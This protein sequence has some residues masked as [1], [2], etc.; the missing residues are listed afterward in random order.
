MYPVKIILRN[1][2][3]LN[4][5]Y[6]LSKVTLI[7]GDNRTG[8]TTLLKA[9]EVGLTGTVYDNEARRN[10]TFD[11]LVAEGVNSYGVRTIFDNGFWI[12][13]N[14]QRIEDSKGDV[15]V[16]QQLD[17]QG[18]PQGAIGKIRQAEQAL[19]MV[20][21]PST[22]GLHISAIVEA[23]TTERRKILLGML[24]GATD[25][26]QPLDAL[27]SSKAGEVGSLLPDDLPRLAVLSKEQTGKVSADVLILDRL[28]R[29]NAA[30][31]ENLKTAKSN[32][33]TTTETIRTLGFDKAETVDTSEIPDLDKQV[34][35]LDT[36]IEQV[37]RSIG[38]AKTD[39]ERSDTLKLEIMEIEDR[40]K[41][42]GTILDRGMIEA[43]KQMKA[44]CKDQAIESIE[45]PFGE[46]FKQRERGY[47]QSLEAFD[48]R[49]Q[50]QRDIASQLTGRINAATDGFR[51]LA[52]EIDSIKEK[53]AA[54]EAHVEGDEAL[55]NC[56]LCNS[57][58]DVKELIA[59]F[60]GIIQKAN[61]DTDALN[62][63]IEKM[64]EEKRTVLVKAAGIEDEK[65]AYRKSY[66]EELKKYSDEKDAKIQTILADYNAA[67]I[68]LAGQLKTIDDSVKLSNDR[69]KKESELS[70]I[71][72][73]DVSELESQVESLKRKRTA[74][75]ERLGNL[76]IAESDAKRKTTLES[77]QLNQMREVRCLDAL[78]KAT[79][80]QGIPGDLLKDKITPFTDGVNEVLHRFAPDMGFDIK[81]QDDRGKESCQF[82][83][84]GREG[85]TLY[86]SASGVE[87]RLILFAIVIHL[88]NQE[89]FVNQR[90]ITLD[91]ISVAD[92]NM[93][94]ILIEAA[95]IAVDKGLIDAAYLAGALRNS[96]LEII[97]ERHQDVFDSMIVCS[98][99]T[100]EVA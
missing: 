73:T 64:R 62:K 72:I 65:A 17:F 19:A 25:D 7:T 67:L 16:K 54:L 47:F 95:K 28:Y 60:N 24:V 93:A 3:L 69:I 96:D 90:I 58:I 78:K 43:D 49:I 1:F 45:I 56:P 98:A 86:E 66:N 51:P 21:N 77:T 50:E 53:I 76:K 12:D 82:G 6:P 75:D 94:A 36:D 68:P 29:I 32:L 41:A 10:S 85:W 97:M 15:T 52:T 89:K 34:K 92:Q 61:S 79:G 88:M 30:V 5:E 38:S 35:N 27:I 31:D 81:F 23:K 84:T 74:L 63:S 100:V 91:E 26:S 2:G 83:F 33:N 9:L 13:R 8:K 57:L 80:P 55:S 11:E 18:I 48:A 42:L 14:F 37:S 44:S 46:E 39:N 40:E 71:Q 59:H 22:Y 87:K 20:I 4:G 70:G 99:K